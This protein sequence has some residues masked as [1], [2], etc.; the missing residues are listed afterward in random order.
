M[1]ADTQ[2]AVTASKTAELQRVMSPRSLA[3]LAETAP[4]ASTM[5]TQSVAGDNGELQHLL[6]TTL[7]LPAGRTTPS[8][9]AF[10]RHPSDRAATSSCSFQGVFALAI[11]IINSVSTIH[12]VPAHTSS[13]FTHL[14]QQVSTQSWVVFLRPSLCQRTAVFFMHTSN[15]LLPHN[16]QSLPQ[17][18]KKS[19]IICQRF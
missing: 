2:G 10:S 14:P 12:C 6:P 13:C 1:T 9:P 18:N 4:G 15:Q 11:I 5:H 16:N 7:C 8:L 19:A 17:E 3:S